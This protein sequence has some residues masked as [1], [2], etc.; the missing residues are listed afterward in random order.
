MNRTAIIDTKSAT[1]W[2]DD[3]KIVHMRMKEDGKVDLEEIKIHFD[4]YKKLGCNSKE[5]L[6]LF[7][8]GV[9]FSFNEEA[10]KYASKH[11][12]DYFIASAIVNNSLAVKL[13]VDIYNKFFNNTFKF[14]SF[15]KKSE[16]LDWLKT[17]KREK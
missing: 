9:F 13:L 10:M 4:I 6:H 8:G 11:L 1:I 2:V 17:L 12:K 7:E 14:R 15:N 5:T 16:A 3:E